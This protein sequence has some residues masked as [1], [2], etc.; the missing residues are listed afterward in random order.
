MILSRMAGDENT[1]M[2]VRIAEG[3]GDAAKVAMIKWPVLNVVARKPVEVTPQTAKRAYERYGQRGLQI[4][5]SVQDWG[6]AE[7]AIRKDE[8]QK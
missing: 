6:Q 3:L 1:P 7:R 2:L 8:P 4:G 5:R